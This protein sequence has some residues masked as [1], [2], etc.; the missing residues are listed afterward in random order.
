MRQ[1]TERHQEAQRH[2]A[3]GQRIIDRQRAIVE[4]LKALKRDT[5]TSEGL[6]AAFE[7]SQAIFESDLARIRLERE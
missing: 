4:R 1:W 2:V 5:T 6:L 7:C 3:N